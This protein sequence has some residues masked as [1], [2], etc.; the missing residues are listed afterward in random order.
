MILNL[1]HCEVYVIYKIIYVNNILLC[2]YNNGINHSNP[3][4]LMLLKQIKKA[5]FYKCILYTTLV[6]TDP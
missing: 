5:S 3:N 1:A 2:C 4:F 6:P